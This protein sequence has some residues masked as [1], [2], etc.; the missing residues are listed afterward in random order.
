LWGNLGGHALL[1]WVYSKHND[2]IPLETTFMDVQQNKLKEY[3]I[4]NQLFYQI[5]YS[6]DEVG[7]YIKL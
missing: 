4:R 7:E 2:W 3:T 5:R 6:F 1:G